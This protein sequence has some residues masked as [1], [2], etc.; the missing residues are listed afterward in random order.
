MEQT[1]WG[2][3]NLCVCRWRARPGGQPGGWGGWGGGV[4]VG[5]C[6]GTLSELP[7]HRKL[8]PNEFVEV[9]LKFIS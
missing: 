2:H 8:G 6:Q 1:A 7:A 5:V 4:G 9:R 3:R